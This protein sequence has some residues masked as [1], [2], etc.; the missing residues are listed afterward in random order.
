MAYSTFKNNPDN[1]LREALSG[2]I[3]AHPCAQWNRAGFASRPAKAG[4]VSVVSGGG[5]G[6]EPLHL[7]FVGEGMLTAAVPGNVFTSPNAVQIAEATRAVDAGSGVVHVVKNY[8]GDMMNFSVAARQVEAEVRTVVVA[9]D[10]ATDSAD[11]PGRRGIL[12]T[13]LVEKI[14]GASA[15]RGDDVDTVARIA[16]EAA[17]ATRSMSVAFAPGHLPTTGVTTFDLP[18]GKAEMGVGIHGERGVERADAA[19]ASEVV[20]R[21]LERLVTPDAREVVLAVG[22]LGSTTTLETGLVFNAALQQLAERGLVVRRAVLGDLVTAVDMHGVSLSVMEATAERLELLDAPTT[23]P[24]WPHLVKDPELVD[25]SIAIDDEMPHDGEVNEWLSA[26]VERVLGAVDDL[27]AL[28]RQAG[29]GDFGHNMQA[30]L[31]GI[32]LPIRGSDKD[33]AQA[34]ARRF[35]VRAGGTSGAVLGTLFDELSRE[36]SRSVGL[37]NA[38]EAITE[39]GGARV[40]DNT[41]IDA[42]APAADTQSNDLDVL[43]EAAA[44]GA[45]STRDL[46]ASKGRASYVGEAS[47]GVIDPGAIVVAWLFGGSGNVAEF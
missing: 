5:S 22:G 9:D 1:F 2:L 44:Q 37:R 12:G 20:A 45:R 13:V 34:L 42:L 21:L 29:D 33:V 15:G 40:G 10:V 47:Q 36:D 6:H 43:Y 46:V 7:G 28:D 8:T 31:G 19:Q 17:D 11:G 30:A 24:A 3:T 14:A 35:L 32:E 41:L 4:H 18:E 26:F 39:L 27:T 23:A 38:V 16:Q 25:A